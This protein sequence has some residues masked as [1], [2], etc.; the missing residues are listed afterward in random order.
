[1]QQALGKAR[2]Q[3]GKDAI[4]LF[5]VELPT[6]VWQDIS[7][8]G[9]NLR[10]AMTRYGFVRR[11]AGY[12]GDG[13]LLVLDLKSSKTK[14]KNTQTPQP[15]PEIKPMTAEEEAEEEARRYISAGLHPPVHVQRHLEFERKVSKEVADRQAK[16]D[17]LKRLQEKI[18]ELKAQRDAQKEKPCPQ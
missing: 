4:D 15:K 13:I 2:A 14:P 12:N 9:L 17:E 11:E 16:H 6:T 1:M 10:S 8:A 5:S 18:A 7:R 3:Y